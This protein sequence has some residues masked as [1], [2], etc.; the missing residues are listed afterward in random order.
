ML[1]LRFDTNY[2]EADVFYAGGRLVDSGYDLETAIHV[3]LLT[4]A[5]AQA[6]DVLAPDTPRRGHW[7]DVLDP[8][9]R[10]L[11]SRLWLLEQAEATE[12][13]AQ[14]ART[15]AAEALQWMIDDRHVRSF[16]YETEVGDEDISMVV[17]AVTREG[18]TQRVGPFK[19]TG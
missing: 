8:E 13:T 7:A 5:P 2:A 16:E 17:V 3:S 15:Y 1:A 18:R 12:S 11:G 9:G 6:G 4:D 10:V 19:V 14:R